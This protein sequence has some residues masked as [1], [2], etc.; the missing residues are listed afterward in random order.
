M[1]CREVSSGGTPCSAAVTRFFCCCSCSAANA[2]GR[3]RGA[4]APCIEQLVLGTELRLQPMADL[5]PAALVLR[6]FLAPDDFARI[7]VFAQDRFVFVR[8]KGI[9]LLEADDGNR[10][11]LL[12]RAATS[13]G[14]N[15]LCRCKTRSASLSDGFM[16]SISS[17]TV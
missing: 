14:R 6:L 16:S 11:R 15:T 8:G 10:V 17:I 3:R 5:V 4:G 2:R 13:A 1:V 12:P 9:E 7:R